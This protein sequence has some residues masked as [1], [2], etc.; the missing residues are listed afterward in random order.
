MAIHDAN[1]RCRACAAVLRDHVIDLGPQPDPDRLLD[2]DDP[3]DAPVAPVDVWICARCGL[4]QLVGER[5]P[6]GAPPH[7]HGPSAD[8]A[9]SSWV[10]DLVRGFADG[11]GPR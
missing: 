5:P 2:P 10:D 9:G 4:L 6:G 1:P 8:I 3:L 7:G 11:A